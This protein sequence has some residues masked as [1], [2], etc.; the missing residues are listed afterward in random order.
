MAQKY[1]G[2]VEHAFA[3]NRNVSTAI[4]SMS[5]HALTS[6]QLV[7][8]PYRSLSELEVARMDGTGGVDGEVRKA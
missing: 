6:S 5:L 8:D 1:D 4:L 7:S 2:S 3:I